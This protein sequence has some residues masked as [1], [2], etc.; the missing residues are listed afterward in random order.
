MCVPHLPSTR[1]GGT[2]GPVPQFWTM[3][4]LLLSR[5]QGEE[6][7]E[8]NSENQTVPEAARSQTKDEDKEQEELASF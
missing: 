3:W 1:Q 2:P 5:G 8:L 6:F 4:C 7:L